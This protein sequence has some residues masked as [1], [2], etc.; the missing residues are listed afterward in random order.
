MNMRGL[1]GTSLL[2]ADK[3]EAGV[4]YEKTITDVTRREFDD[5]VKPIVHFDDGTSVV[6]NAT[7]GAVLA[8]AFGFESDNYLGRTIVVRQGDT[9]FG[10]KPTKCIV[11]ETIGNPRVEAKATATV[12]RIGGEGK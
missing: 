2:N 8:T 9:T 5:G 6:V 3:L 4:R 1:I 11:F 12:R 10:G 7:R